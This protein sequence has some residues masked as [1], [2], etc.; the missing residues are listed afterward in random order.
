VP[1]DQVDFVGD[2]AVILSTVSTSV[3]TDRGVGPGSS[4]AQ[5]TAAYPDADCGPTT[6]AR[7]YQCNVYVRHSDGANEQTSWV[8]DSERDGAHAAALSVFLA[9]NPA[10]P[11]P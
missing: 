2:R 8:W 3:R 7:Y 9:A 10:A 5:V 1:V 6:N 11:A 4:E